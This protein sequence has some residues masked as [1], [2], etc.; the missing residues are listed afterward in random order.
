MA[1]EL[2]G[3]ARYVNR[4]VTWIRLLNQD[5]IYRQLI[6]ELRV[7]VRV[8]LDKAE[9]TEKGYGNVVSGRDVIDVTLELSES[10]TYPRTQGSV[11]RVMHSDHEIVAQI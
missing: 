1:G 5:T 2:L 10:R 11:R 7:R 4:R 6:G 9:M 8:C 3:Q